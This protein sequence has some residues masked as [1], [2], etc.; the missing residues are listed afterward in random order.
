MTGTAFTA[1][2][3]ATLCTSSYTSLIAKLS[4]CTISDTG[5]NIVLKQAT[6]NDNAGKLSTVTGTAFTASDFATICTSYTTRFLSFV[7]RLQ[8]RTFL[9]SL[10][11]F[12]H[13]ISRWPI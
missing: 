4:A 13:N 12:S 2:D 6:L 11:M 9:V 10:F 8:C 1:S 7:R 3:F 5:G